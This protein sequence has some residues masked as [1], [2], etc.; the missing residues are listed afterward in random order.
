MATAAMAVQD[1]DYDALRRQS[2][3]TTVVS[4]TVAVNHRALITRTLSK[5]PVN[6]AL[7]RELIQN[8]ADAGATTVRVEFETDGRPLRMENIMD[9]HKALVKRVRIMND[10]VNFRPEDW[11]RLREIAKGNPD[12]TKIGAFGVGFYSVFAVTEQP[13]VHSGPTAMSFYYIGDQLH[14][15]RM[16]LPPSGKWTLVD[17]PYTSPRA[18]PALADFTSFI[19]QSLTFVRLQRIELVVDGIDLLTMAKTK[20]QAQPL[21]IPRGINTKSPDGLV[22]VTGVETE[23]VKIEARYLNATQLGKSE[24]EAKGLIAFGLKFMQ[25]F[26]TETERPGDYT[27]ATLYLRTV[28]ATASTHPSLAFAK[29]L[30]A[31]IIKPPPRVATVSM[32]ALNKAEAD[33]SA[34]RSGIAS[35]IF[36]ASFADAKVF[37]GFPTKQTTG[38]R[39]HIAASQAIPTME[40]AAVDMS[41][42]YVRDWNREMMYTAGVVARIVYGAE[43]AAIEALV[44]PRPGKPDLSDAVVAQTAHTMRQFYF[45]SSTPDPKVGQYVAAGFWRSAPSVPLLTNKGVVASTQARVMEDVTFLRHVPI[46]LPGLYAQAT[47]FLDQV[48][49]VGLIRPVDVT[50]IK[51]EFGQRTLDRTDVVAFLRWLTGK[52]RSG[53][54]SLAEA[55]AV[56]AY[57]VVADAELGAVDLRSIMYYHNTKTI[58]ADMPVPFTCMPHAIAKDLDVHAMDTL[59]WK[60]LEVLTWLWHVTTSDG[61]KLPVEHSISVSPQFSA[62]VLKVLARRWTTMP[63]QWHTIVLDQLGSKTCI[64]TQKGMRRPS[65]AYLRRVK[66]FADLPVMDA[67]L[68]DGVSEAMLVYLGVRKTVE[69]K[70]VMDRLHGE[71]ERKWSTVDM[72]TYLASQQKDMRREDFAFLKANA[73][74]EAEDGDRL[75]K[76]SAL[77]QPS[78]ELRALKLPTLKWPQWNAQ[79]AEAQFLF[80]LGLLEAPTATSLVLLAAAAK[81]PDYRDR[82]LAYFLRFYDQNGYRKAADALA[83]HR[84]LPAALDGR[85][86]LCAPGECFSSTYAAL[87]GYPVLDEPLRTESW[88]FGVKMYPEVS[89]LVDRLIERPPTTVERA[90]PVFTYMAGRLSE[91]S[92]ADLAKLNKAKF[93]PTFA[94][95]GLVLQS[96]LTVFI[97]TAAA[98]HELLFYKQFFS[99]VSFE[100]GAN[101]FLRHCGARDKPSVKELARSTVDAP[102]EMYIQAGSAEKYMDLLAEFERS[103]AEISMD[104]DLLSKMKRSPFVIARKYAAAK[105]KARTLG[106]A[107]EAEAEDDFFDDDEATF[108]LAKPTETVVADDVILFNLFKAEVLSAPADSTL[109]RFYVKIGSP[110]ISTM[111]DETQRIG[112]SMN[113]TDAVA[114]M[115]KKIVERTKLYAETSQDKL[116]VPFSQFES[117]V[118]VASV[119]SIFLERSL[120][121]RSRH[122]APVRTPTSACLM[123]NTDNSYTLYLTANFE[124]FDVSQTLINTLLQ[125]PTPAEATVLESLLNSPLA[126]LE[127]RGYNVKKIIKSQKQDAKRAEESA[128]LLEEAREQERQRKAKAAEA[129]AAQDEA[130]KLRAIDTAKN[131]AVEPASPRSAKAARSP[132][133]SPAASPS[134]LPSPAKPAGD[135]AIVAEAMAAAA[136]AQAVNAG[137]QAGG[138]TGI[139][140]KWRKSI[141]RPHGDA[142]GKRDDPFAGVSPIRPG[143]FPEDPEPAA[144]NAVGPVRGPSAASG[145]SPHR[146]GTMPRESPTRPTRPRGSPGAPGAGQGPPGGPLSEHA[147]TDLLYTGLDHIR[148]YAD[149]ELRNEAQE[150]EIGGDVAASASMAADQ[151]CDRTVAHDL[152]RYATIGEEGPKL[153]INRMADDLPPGMELPLSDFAN[154]LQKLAHIFGCRFDAFHVFFDPGA[155]SVAFNLGGS[156]F[157]NAKYFLIDVESNHVHGYDERLALDYWF[158]VLA[159]ELAHNLAQNHGQEHSFF[160]ESYVQRFLGPYRAL[161]RHEEAR[162]GTFA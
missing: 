162:T 65:E 82:L 5:Y 91:L 55:K 147:V 4:E 7:F 40:R 154:V 159:H 8:G 105:P 30:Q 6:H 110:R 144:D 129:K 22:Q 13:M 62:A 117:R 45:D 50:D 135:D 24:Q 54:M 83:S 157:F 86:Q 3:S 107:D 33:S 9:A 10:G 92:P 89:V 11:D 37:I 19:A 133:V 95:G 115:L 60:E 109:E 149:W 88:K 78:P 75:H 84:F 36:P 53:D 21:A 51:N 34:L 106:R 160:S 23:A 79:S 56:M 44:Q 68:Y 96:P 63:A 87:F 142:D 128:R 73:F 150:W 123:R 155:V 80:G 67:A 98:S 94:S 131:A 102:H 130:R 39:S 18:L 70:Y 111:V 145:E 101:A 124:W 122:V 113:T 14:Y 100:P 71:G 38:L 69:L 127:R 2:D 47:E 31:A 137:M 72:V 17:L 153:F 27:A 151:S 141:M 49:T 59:G 46:I 119:T 118:K 1:L 103:W 85:P 57:A 81:A 52:I 138:L 120:R 97:D 152:K 146:R 66:L 161:L 121:M 76:P 125:R 64:A 139:F 140:S 25:T 143:A 148:P 74:C 116:K 32:I 99:F 12:E 16:T 104:P 114:P 158:P 61:S 35:Q 136:R 134:P 20:G 132:A 28:T 48:R 126:S 58:P 90:N 108:V 26:A 29:R 93:V 112:A 77:Y 41:N 156:L 15:K 43:M 42:A